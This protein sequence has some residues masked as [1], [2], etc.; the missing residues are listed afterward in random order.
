MLSQKS[1]TPPALPYPP[2]PIFFALAFPCYKKQ[3]IT[4]F[5]LLFSM[6]PLSLPISSPLSAI[7]LYLHTVNKVFFYYKDNFKTSIQ[8]EPPAFLLL[9]AGE[10]HGMTESSCL[11]LKMIVFLAIT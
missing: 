4:Q 10:G 3:Y 11:R 9:L 8:I 1:P 2:I 5:F 6:A 7:L